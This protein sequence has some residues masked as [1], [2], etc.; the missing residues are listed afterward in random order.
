MLLSLKL[1]IWAPIS[2]TWKDERCG[3]HDTTHDSDTTRR[4]LLDLIHLSGP[5]SGDHIQIANV[6]ANAA[7][8][9]PISKIMS[10]KAVRVLFSTW[11]DD[12]I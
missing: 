9:R 4:L 7:Y 1:D 6:N 10:M 5:P 2:T 12:V 8:A 3:A 11:G